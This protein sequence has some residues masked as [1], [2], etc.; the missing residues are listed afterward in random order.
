MIPMG[1]GDV[2]TINNCKEMVEINSS[3]SMFDQDTEDWRELWKVEEEEK[4]SHNY[5]TLH[6]RAVSCIAAR[7]IQ[8]HV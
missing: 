4:Q 7:S 5:T 1:K 8:N 6:F 3:L 2:Y